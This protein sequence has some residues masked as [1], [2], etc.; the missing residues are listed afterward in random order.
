MKT[1]VK[2]IPTLVRRD[3]RGASSAGG[4]GSAGNHD[5][6]VPGDR[7][8]REK[9]QEPAPAFVRL[10]LA[11]KHVQERSRQADHCRPRRQATA[12]DLPEL[13][14]RKVLLP[15]DLPTSDGLAVG[16]EE[17]R[18]FPDPPRRGPL[19]HGC[20]QDD[21]GSKVNL[22][23]EEPRRWRRHPLAATVPLATE[24]EPTAVL[25]G[26]IIAAA[27]LARVLG[28][29]QPAAAR[30]R[31]LAC[32]LAKSSSIENRNAQNLASQGKL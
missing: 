9:P 22:S 14:L 28:R 10:V 26:Q 32:V 8:R 1:T 16:A 17:L 19:P 27:G 7:D 20:D 18:K 3:R 15:K 11:E 25:L 4:P 23:T 31:L 30:A 13:R 5:R 24:T 2:P 29:M 6:Q 21:H 12:F